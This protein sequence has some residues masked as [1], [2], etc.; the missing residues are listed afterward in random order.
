MTR[1]FIFTLG[2]VFAVGHLVNGR[3]CSQSARVR[4]RGESIPCSRA[5]TV[6]DV[7]RY[8]KGRL[9]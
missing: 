1:F 9:R 7:S 3:F 5:G 2:S 8:G 4:Q 6:S